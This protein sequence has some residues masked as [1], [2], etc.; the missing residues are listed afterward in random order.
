M[1]RLTWTANAN[2]RLTING[3]LEAIKIVYHSLRHMTANG[4]LD[5][6]ILRDSWGKVCNELLV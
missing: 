6:V 4:S 1:Y 5:E 2:K 3:T